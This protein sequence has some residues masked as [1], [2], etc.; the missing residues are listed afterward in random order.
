[1]QAQRTAR[2]CFSKAR[3]INFMFA[4]HSRGSRNGVF[5]HTD[6]VDHRNDIHSQV[7]KQSW[8]AAARH[9]GKVEAISWSK[10]FGVVV[11]L[12]RNLEGKSCNC[13]CR[14]GSRHLCGSE[15]HQEPLSIFDGRFYK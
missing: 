5:F 4:R 8:N 2:L 13:I 1:M 15:C 6:K 10:Q 9:R 12:D 11:R 3:K 7:A 14:N